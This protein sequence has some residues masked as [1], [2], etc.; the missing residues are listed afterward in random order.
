MISQ[1]GPHK[2]QHGDV[3]NG[4]KALMGNDKAQIMYSD[5]P[6][7]NGNIKY[8]ATMNKKMNGEIN[9]PAPLP[10]FLD[11]IF[12]IAQK[13]VI[14]FLLIE[15]GVR[16]AADIKKRGC[17]AGFNNCGLVK[18]QYRSGN[19][20]L[21]LDLHLFAKTGYQYPDNFVSDVSNT[22]GYATAS[23]SVALLA[24]IIKQ[25]NPAPIILDPCCGMGYTAQTAID[26]G[27]IFR[28][29]ELNQK[30]LNKTLARF[31]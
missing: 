11:A 3:T 31:K 1:I 13:Y 27:L 26:N 30:R 2:V 17:D 6:W 9:T 5:P 23:K 15:Y 25:S 22:Y 24:P 21:P 20:L 4:I 7:G 28:G 18:T 12:D 10:E 14:G 8:W 29:N 16:W 19:R